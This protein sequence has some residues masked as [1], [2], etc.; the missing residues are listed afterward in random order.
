MTGGGSS[1]EKK[2]I[3]LRGNKNDLYD[4]L[5]TLDFGKRKNTFSLVLLTST[6]QQRNDAQNPKFIHN[7]VT[8]HAEHRFPKQKGFFLFL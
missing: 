2:D 5:P 1:E 4:T 8:Q 7:T 6:S 3:K